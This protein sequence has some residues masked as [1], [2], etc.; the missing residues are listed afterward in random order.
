MLSRNAWPNA[1]GFEY[2]DQEFGLAQLMSDRASPFAAHRRDV[3]VR[4]RM[5]EGMTPLR[6][7][8]PPSSEAEIQHALDKFG[9]GHPGFLGGLGKLFTLGDFRVGVGF[10][11]KEFA[12]CTQAI[13]DSG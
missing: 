2:H 7:A 6:A 11:E 10:E 8:L 1:V 12:V 4:A 9:V 3:S 13:I 5:R